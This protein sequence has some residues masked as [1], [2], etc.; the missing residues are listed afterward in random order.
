MLRP[1]TQHEIYFAYSLG[2]QHLGLLQFPHQAAMASAANRFFAVG[3]FRPDGVFTIEV[4]F[5]AVDTELSGKTVTL[6]VHTGYNIGDLKDDIA[7]SCGCQ[8]ADLRLHFYSSILQTRFDNMRN[9]GKVVGYCIRDGAMVECTLVR[10]AQK[11][12]RASPTTPPRRRKL[13]ATGT[14]N[15]PLR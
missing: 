6:N 1:L 15:P 7:S 10:K 13:R 3:G 9:H 12:R 14:D 8:A 5:K 4:T 2:P 11:R